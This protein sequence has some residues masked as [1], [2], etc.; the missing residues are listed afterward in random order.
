MVKIQQAT[1]NLMRPIHLMDIIQY[2]HYIAHPTG[3]FQMFMRSGILEKRL[4]IVQYN[5]KEAPK[6][7]I[8]T[9]IG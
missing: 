2:H 3:S 8:G 7:G 1:T 5:T 9:D 6:E 4:E